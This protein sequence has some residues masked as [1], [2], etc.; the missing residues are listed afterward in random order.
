MIYQKTVIILSGEVSALV[1]CQKAENGIRVDVNAN[2][3]IEQGK[4]LVYQDDVRQS[5]D[6]SFFANK[7][8]FDLNE[9]INPSIA[10]FCLFYQGRPVASGSNKREKLPIEHFV[11][12]L[13]KEEVMEEIFKVEPVEQEKEKAEK[14]PQDLPAEESG[15]TAFENEGNIVATA[16]KTTETYDDEALA[17]EDYFSAVLNSD[18]ESEVV[19]VQIERKNSLRKIASEQERLIK[20]TPSEQERIFGRELSYYEKVCDEIEEFFKA[21]ERVES[22]E[23]ALPFTRWVKVDYDGT[24]GY[25]VGLIGEKPDYICYGL[26]GRYEP[27]AP[28]DLQNYC[29]W[30][31][32]D[33]KDPQGEGY[34]LIYQSA[35]TG[36]SVKFDEKP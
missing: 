8:S 13:E 6:L 22:M 28:E 7:A 19:K 2:F 35:I 10:D 21:G 31:P 16:E 3:P 36:K 25:V 32:K 30:L 5:Y 27:I 24:A 15:E 12:P 29:Q 14:A 1:K 23:K 33:V 20:H 4:L 17:D 18:E 11:L 34:W 9:R 26:P